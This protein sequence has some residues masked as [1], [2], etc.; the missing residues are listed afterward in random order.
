MKVV[1]LAGG[2]GSRISEY[3]DSMPKPMI[4][5]GSKPILWHIMNY[6]SKFGH[7]EFNIALGYKAE[8]IKEY[9]LNYNIHN[10]NFT[11]NLKN[12]NIIIEKPSTEDWNVSLIQTGL[13]TMTGGRVKKMKNYIDNK[14]FF[15]SYGDSIGNINISELLNFHNSHNKLITVTAV[16]PQARFGEL[17]IENNQVKN[18]SEKPQ[19]TD[20]WINGGFFV[21]KPEFLDYIQGD[22]TILE[23]EPL[24]KAALE[25]QLMSYKHEGEWYCMD[26]L[27]DKENLESVLKSKKEF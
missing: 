9:F 13:N 19:V 22:N 14:S 8:K 18:F 16:R 26:T 17:E 3:T 24:E 11:I 15:L 12:K 20:G 1:I 6:Y 4:E 5:I 7:K 27:R 2:R 21:I 23:K 25:G 10:S